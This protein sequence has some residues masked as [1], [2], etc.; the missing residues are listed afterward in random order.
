MILTFE[1]PEATLERVG[2]KGAS[3]A[4]LARA[5]YPVPP[6]FLITTHAYRT[7]VTA[8]QLNERLAARVSA[9]QPN[10]APPTAAL[11]A[12]SD[13]IRTWFDAGVIPADLASMIRGAYADLGGPPVAVRSSATA[14]DLPEMSFAGQQDTFLNVRGEAALLEAVVRCWS[15]LWTARAIGY[16]T[17]NNITEADLALAVVVQVMV[18]SEASGVMFTANPLTGLRTETVIGATFGLGEA[19]VSGQVDPD[20]YV[21]DMIRGTIVSKALGAKAIAI[22][23]RAGGGVEKVAEGLGQ[24]QALPDAQI[25]DLAQLGQRVMGDCGFPQDIEWAWAKGQFHLLQ[26]R[27][28]TSLYPLPEGLAGDPLHVFFSFGAVQG[29]LDPLTPLGQDAI[30]NVAVGAARLVAYQTTYD[31]QP[32]LRLAGERLW[33]EIT[34]VLRNGLGRRVARGMLRLVEPSVGRVVEKIGDDPRL[35]PHRPAPSFNA[36]RHALH[37]LGPLAFNVIRFLSNPDRRRVQ[38]IQQMDRVYADFKARYRPDGDRVTHLAGR[39][40]ALRE[41]CLAFPHILPTLGS[42]LASGMATFNI[43]L[44]IAKRLPPGAD[45]RDPSQLVLELTRGLPHNVTTQMDLILWQTARTLKA[46]PTAADYVLSTPA[47]RLAAEYLR[48]QLPASAQRAAGA[49]LERYGFRGLGEIDLGR[50]RWAENPTPVFQALQSYLRI[51]DESRAPDVVFKRGEQ[52][53]LNALGQLEAAARATAHGW[54]KA[55]LIHG[56]ALRMRA[57]IGMRESPKFYVVRM[58]EVVRS[59][60]LASGRELV[61]AGVLDQADDVFFLKLPELEELS[62]GAGRDWR[63]LVAARRALYEREKLR[64]QIPRVLLSDGRA[65]YEGLNDAPSGAGE[66]LIV[67]SPVSPGVVEGAARVV[68]DPHGAQLAPGEILVCPGTDPSWTPLFLAAGGLVMEVGGMMTHG[69]VVAREYGIPA[70]VGVDKATR[71]LLT[72]QRLRVDGS[73]GHIVIVERQPAPSL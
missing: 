25:M 46:D 30:R 31:T 67:G 32:L 35:A 10:S 52:A 73:T 36:I 17:R 60:L 69:S 3:L 39:I 14:E 15:S 61:A 57:S 34:P 55:H 19:L 56:L 2:G 37:L 38:V 28:I 48:G 68:L 51:E 41:L 13:D 29:V 42:G 54:L 27:P 21:V 1:S 45:G 40:A 49:F 71:R 50:P 18:D 72:G 20:H 8:N 9:L 33:I 26:S 64:K 6:G 47:D 62:R 66:D 11:E 16:R 58:M 53:A 43:L 4:R 5:G 65:F 7:Y 22:R 12:A 63:A 70:V 24:R 59:G 44:Q 23:S